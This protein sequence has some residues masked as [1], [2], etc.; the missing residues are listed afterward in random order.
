MHPHDRHDVEVHSSVFRKELGQWDL[1]LT[2]IL[3]IV[4]LGWIG[5]AGKL[6]SSHVSFWLL[7]ILLFYIPSAV[8]VIHLNRRM[9]L[10]GGLYQWAKFGFNEFTGFLVAWNLWLYAMVLMSEVG[11]QTAN[12]I[13]YA[14]GPSAEWFAHNKWMIALCSFVIIGGLM[15]V[16]SIGLTAGKWV[17]NAGALTMLAMFA[18][19]AA[20]AILHWVRGERPAS[21]PF[22]LTLPPLTLLSVN[23][24]GKMGFAA[25][26]GFEYVAIFAGECKDP[27]K[28]IG[29][30]VWI[31]AP[32][33]ACMFIFGTGA[34][35]TFVPVDKIDLVSPSAQVLAVGSRMLGVGASI[36]PTV[37][38]LILGIRIA[39]ASINFSATIRLPMVAGWDD[40][41][42]KWFTQLHAR[43]KTPTYS[44]LFV[45]AMTLA[46][47][48]A[49]NSGVGNQEAYQLLNNGSGIFYALPYLVMFAIP[50][51]GINDASTGAIARPGRWVRIASIS[52]FGMTLLYV[53][54]SVF[55]IIAVESALVFAL[56]IGG[57]IVI[58]NGIGVVV[59]LIG[60]RRQK[61]TG[62]Q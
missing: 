47:G 52:G 14:L 30:S 16:S 34:V 51:I 32:I 3:F 27:V 23:I 55:P 12:N 42:P 39:Q 38:M 13:A 45:G 48:L 7:A 22:A 18:A 43:H 11:L 59:F 61:T 20:L 37:L 28:T 56:K 57:M 53:V 15:V 60:S 35:L 2:Q 6:G 4:G 19:I 26:G 25:L 5:T 17:H 24:L 36:V 29:R 33:I 9:P 58:A 50:L 10:E 21:P 49:G 41:L 54:L 62:S 31:A 8:V 46:L 44:I 40:L 1:V